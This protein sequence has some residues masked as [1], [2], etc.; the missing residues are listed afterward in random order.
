MFLLT[1]KFFIAKFTVFQPQRARSGMAC[2]GTIVGLWHI[3][4]TWMAVKLLGC[5]EVEGI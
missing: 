3:N 2:A 1:N 5:S 4:T